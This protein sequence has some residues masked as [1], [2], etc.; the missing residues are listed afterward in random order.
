MGKNDNESINAIQGIYD[1]YDQVHKFSDNI[2]PFPVAISITG[3]SI[4]NDIEPL[5]R[6]GD[7]REMIEEKL[8]CAL[9]DIAKTIITLNGE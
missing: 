7:Y 4:M 1:K 2:I 5:L 8:L 6:R 9:Q 3:K